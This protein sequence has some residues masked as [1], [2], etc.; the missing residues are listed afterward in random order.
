MA[1][2]E[3]PASEEIDVFESQLGQEIED[4]QSELERAEKNLADA[5][6][7]SAPDKNEGE[8]RQLEALTQK[9]RDVYQKELGMHRKHKNEPEPN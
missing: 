3:K 2:Q 8:I 9:M 6:K 7:K 4:T 5:R 1:H